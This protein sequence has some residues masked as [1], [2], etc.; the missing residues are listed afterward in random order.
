MQEKAL[1]LIADYPSGDDHRAERLLEFFGVPCQRRHTT[2]LSL[3]AT[4]SAEGYR[5]VCAAEAF[6]RVMGELQNGSRDF[7][8]FA[9]QIHSVF[10]YPNGDPVALANVVGQLSGATISIRRGTGGDIQWRI[11]DD[12]GGMCGI[13]RDLRIHPAV[14][15]LRSFDFFHMDGSSASPLIAADD[16]AAFVKLNFNGLPVF[17]S[18][19]RLIDIDTELTTFNFDIRNHLLSAVPLVSYIRWAF[20]CSSWHA[21]ETCACLVIDDPLLKP[22]H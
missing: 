2:E 19:E 1:L 18:S 13:M 22:T 6:A 10:L 7:N 9:R 11:A 17:V 20:P 14:T 4:D 15:A 21:P 16:K 12:P 3:P 8:S 5:L